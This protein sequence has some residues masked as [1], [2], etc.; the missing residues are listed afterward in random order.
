MELLQV[1]CPNCGLP[2]DVND[3]NCS[4]C[5]ATIPPSSGSSSTNMLVATVL[6][7]AL[8]LFAADWYLGMG[9]TE[10]FLEASGQSSEATGQ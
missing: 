4:Y 3:D 10:W 7:F 6:A 9:L 8:G 1:K 2:A 5:F